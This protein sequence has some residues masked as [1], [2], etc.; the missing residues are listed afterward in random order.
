MEAT[1][2]ERKKVTFAKWDPA[3]IIET[4]ET[5]IVFLEEALEENDPDFILRTVGH[6][7]RSRGM[8]RVARELGLDRKGLY[9]SL[10]PDGNPSFRTVFR[11]IDLLGL[12]LKV[13]RKSA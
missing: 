7:V 11:L 1:T 13:E 5:A 12:Q 10:A 6:I 8:A 3:E 2:L 4:K 9:K